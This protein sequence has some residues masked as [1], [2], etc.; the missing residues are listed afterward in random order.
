LF[1]IAADYKI[2]RVKFGILLFT[3]F[4]A[5]IASGLSAQKVTNGLQG[6]FK[7]ASDRTLYDYFSFDGNGTS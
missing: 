2:L 7:A 4:L 3:Y 1:I 5:R 6:Y